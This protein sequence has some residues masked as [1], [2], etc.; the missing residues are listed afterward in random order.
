MSERYPLITAFTLIYNTNPKFVIQAIE[1][2]INNNYPNLQ[3]IIIDDCSPDTTPKTVVKKWISDNNY[4]C[5]FYEH[6]K[7][8]GICGT[9]NHVLELARGKY[10]IGC[11]D[12]I[13]M[14]NTINSLFSEINKSE[15]I[16]VVYGNL[17]MIYNGI[18]QNEIYP[19]NGELKYNKNEIELTDLIKNNCVNAI[20]N[21]MNV[22][23]LKR[24]GGFDQSW[25]F[26]DYPMWIKLILNNY[27]IIR[28][29]KVCSHYRIHEN[30]IS[31]KINWTIANFEI[32]NYFKKNCEIKK[33][34][35]LRLT[36]LS[37]NKFQ[38]YLECLKIYYK[39]M[40]IVN[41]Y[42]IINK[43]KRKLHLI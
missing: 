5:E 28:L 3:H 15:D 37:G 25:M 2:I 42:V 18:L 38:E 1:S 39:Y 43:I 9:I 4:N 17:K 20:G 19:T 22:E 24:I 33:E 41:F 13:L 35:Q 30:N 40:F 32:L 23:I 29:E 36:L 10:I 14:P 12:D 27:R 7:N 31:H 6:D 11:S 16:A 21:L 8:L 26:E 34:L